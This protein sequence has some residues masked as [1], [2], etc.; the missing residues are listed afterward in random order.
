MVYSLSVGSYGIII[1]IVILAVFFF[2]IVFVIVKL[3]K[4]IVE[5]NGGE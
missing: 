3:A 4:I 2:V 1:W 5:K